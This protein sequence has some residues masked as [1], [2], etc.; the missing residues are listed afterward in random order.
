MLFRS[1]NVWVGYGPE[2]RSVGDYLQ[3]AQ[4]LGI[5]LYACSQALHALG[6]SGAD[7][8]KSCTGAGGA[9][10]FMARTLDPQWRSLVF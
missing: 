6:L 5:R 4:A 2:R 7:L 1:A 3:E 8:S 9:V 10:Q